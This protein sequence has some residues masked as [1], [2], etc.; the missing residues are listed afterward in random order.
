MPHFVCEVMHVFL[1][2]R[3]KFNNHSSAPVTMQSK[4]AVELKVAA[5]LVPDQ[6]A[7]CACLQT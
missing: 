7:K 5:Y 2:T 6:I 3:S 4:C 1:A